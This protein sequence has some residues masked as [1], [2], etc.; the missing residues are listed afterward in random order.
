MAI[1]TGQ[2]TRRVPT[3]DWSRF[4]TTAKDATRNGMRAWIDRAYI[5]QGTVNGG[6]AQIKLDGIAS[7]ANPEPNT[8]IRLALLGIPGV[9]PDLASA[10]AN[11]AWKPWNDWFQA[12][13]IS[14]PEAFPTF[15]LWSGS[16]QAPSTPAGPEP[17]PN[18]PRLPFSHPLD[19]GV[20][21]H[22]WLFDAASL[23]QSFTGLTPAELGSVD[24]GIASGGKLAMAA[25]FGTIMAIQSRKLPRPG[26]AKY[27]TPMVG[28]TS[29]QAMTDFANWFSERFRTWKSTAR[30][31]NL[32]G[33]GPVPSYPRPGPVTNGQLTGENVL[34]GFLFG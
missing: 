14:I 12:Y 5:R 32:I 22:E 27:A 30:F 21:L 10:F 34:T 19:L 6:V 9:W 1:Q 31:T 2:T 28:L 18:A 4:L 8:V 24:E 16:N 25:A 15:V 20:S 29:E 26:G 13:Q 11:A 23:V 3:V 7:R 17:P 33:S